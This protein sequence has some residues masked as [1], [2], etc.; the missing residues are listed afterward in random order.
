MN[1]EIIKT[2][3]IP[4]EGVMQFKKLDA[5][6]VTAL[7]IWLVEAIHNP[8][9][10]PLVFKETP[11]IWRVNPDQGEPYLSVEGLQFGIDLKY[12]RDLVD[13]IEKLAEKDHL[14]DDTYPSWYEHISESSIDKLDYQ[15][16]MFTD[17]L[18]G[19]ISVS[20]KKM[21]LLPVALQVHGDNEYYTLVKAYKKEG[22]LF[23]SFD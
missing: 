16:A 2:F 20:R 14:L 6:G 1:I 13:A 15:V 10:A 9:V 8:K 12:A 17:T 22:E 11:F 21:S 3:K 19:Y 5:I 4:F 7:S 23:Y 18:L